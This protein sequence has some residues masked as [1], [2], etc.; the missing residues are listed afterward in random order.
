MKI[1]P[2]TFGL[3]GAI[4]AAVLWSL[5]SGVALFFLIVAMNIS[6]DLAYTDFGNFDWKFFVVR[7]ISAGVA[8][9]VGAGMASWL[10]AVIYNFVSE[11]SVDKLP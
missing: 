8:L 2:T 10:I 5:Y 3:S 7:F 4:A 1:N 9:S 11:I 6:G